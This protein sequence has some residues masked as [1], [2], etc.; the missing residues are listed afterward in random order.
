MHEKERER[1]WSWHFVSCWGEEHG[2]GGWLLRETRRGTHK[3]G[4]CSFIS[5]IF[6]TS[7]PSKYVFPLIKHYDPV[8]LDVILSA[9]P[10]QTLSFQTRYSLS[11]CTALCVT[12]K[13]L[14]QD[15]QFTLSKNTQTKSYLFFQT[16][17]T[18]STKTSSLFPLHLL[19]SLIH[20]LPIFLPFL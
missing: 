1:E 12:L 9:L 13:I 5:S 14:V 15:G 17:V 11:D 20:F 19:L 3:K 4:F 10:S 18:H 7:H 6:I 8:I 16:F 2:L